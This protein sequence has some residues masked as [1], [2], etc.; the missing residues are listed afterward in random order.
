ENVAKKINFVPPIRAQP[1]DHDTSNDTDQDLHGER[2]AIPPPARNGCSHRVVIS[3]N[4]PCWVA[5]AW[6][7]RDAALRRP[8][9]A[10][11][12]P[13][14]SRSYQMYAQFTHVR[15]ASRMHVMRT[16][17]RFVAF[18]ESLLEVS[19]AAVCDC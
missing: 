17:T 16:S 12:C 14:H 2:W 4:T 13:Y 19:E 10:A 1:S 9:I 6:V 5:H 3:I 11:R 15:N 18:A 8:D 7:G